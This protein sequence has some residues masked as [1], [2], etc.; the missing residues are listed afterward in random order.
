MER[1]SVFDAMISCVLLLLQLGAVALGCAVSL[2]GLTFSVLQVRKCR[3]NT[4]QHEN[5][6]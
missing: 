1:R 5:H 3:Y 4:M 2:V 6:Q